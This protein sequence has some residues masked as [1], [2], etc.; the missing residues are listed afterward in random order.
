M[1]DDINQKKYSRKE[2]EE[3]LEKMFMN[4]PEKLQD[5]LASDELA[6]F[7]DSLKDKYHLNNEEAYT[8]INEV[9]AALLLTTPLQEAKDAIVIGLRDRSE[10]EIEKIMGELEENVFTPLVKMFSDDSDKEKSKKN[11]EE[12]KN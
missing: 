8:L 2:G 1:Q 3:V 12:E 9:T 7:M 4:L 10:A 11:E 6:K 5:F